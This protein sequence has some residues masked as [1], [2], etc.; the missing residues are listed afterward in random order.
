MGSMAIMGASFLAS[1]LL[2]YALTP[3]SPSMDAT[4]Y[5]LLMQT[6]KQANAES[7]A[8][9]ARIEEAKKREELRQQQLAGQ[10]ILT[11]DNGVDSNKVGVKDQVLGSQPDE[12]KG[13]NSL[14][15]Q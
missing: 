6:Q 15:V 11:S 10:N 1:S 3:K 13:S 7:E 8:A 12:R 9:K 2:S 14:M 4:N 5:E